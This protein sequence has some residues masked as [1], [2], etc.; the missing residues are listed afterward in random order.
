MLLPGKQAAEVGDKGQPSEAAH[1][2]AELVQ[3]VLGRPLA[4]A[5]QA[6][7]TSAIRLPASLLPPLSELAGAPTELPGAQA[8]RGLECGPS[9][10]GSRQLGA[11]SWVVCRLDEQLHGVAAAAQLH[12]AHGGIAEAPVSAAGNAAVAGIQ[13]SADAA[14]AGNSRH[15][16]R[17]SSELHVVRHVVPHGLVDGEVILSIM[18][19]DSS[20]TSSS[21]SH[22][23]G[24]SG[25][26]SREMPLP[27]LL[28]IFQAVPWQLPLQLQTLQLTLDGQ[29][30]RT[31]LLR[32]GET[33]RQLK[34]SGE[35]LLFLLCLLHALTYCSGPKACSV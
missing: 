18:A 2:V 20:T 7:D 21:G 3:S 10:E 19:S 8:G 26:S 24:G 28:H 25:A 4:P 34:L 32:V 29:V 9:S 1:R 17:L 33:A 23:R 6:A 30:R 13:Q 31:A 16:V 22:G 5:C 15:D 35:L 27:A 11:L 12:A 14:T